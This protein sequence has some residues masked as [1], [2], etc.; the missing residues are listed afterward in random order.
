MHFI[1]QKLFLLEDYK[2]IQ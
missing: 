2:T 1:T